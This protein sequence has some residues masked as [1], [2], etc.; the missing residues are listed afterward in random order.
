MDQIGSQVSS[1]GL[2]KQGLSKLGKAYW[3][4]STPSLYQA[5]ISRGEARLAD[6]GPIGGDYRSTYRPFRQ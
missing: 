4:L 3:N 1:H 5:A 6:G 2:D